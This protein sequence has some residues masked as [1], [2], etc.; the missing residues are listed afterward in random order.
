[1]PI[2][3]VAIILRCADWDAR[4]LPTDEEALERSRST[5]RSVRTGS[6]AATEPRP[7]RRPSA[8]TLGGLD[9]CP[10]SAPTRSSLATAHG[11]ARSAPAAREGSGRSPPV[12]HRRQTRL[13]AQARGT[14]AIQ[15]WLGPEFTPHLVVETVETSL[16]EPQAHAWALERRVPA[17]LR[18]SAPA[19]GHSKGG[20]AEESSER[21]RTSATGSSPERRSSSPAPRRQSESRGELHD[22]PRLGLAVLESR[23]RGAETTDLPSPSDTDRPTDGSVSVEQPFESHRGDRGCGDQRQQVQ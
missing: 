4:W 12:G 20:G 18:R 19:W 5:A 17:T 1:M 23:G 2:V 8:I 3:S 14:A 15:V 21:A 22:F 6:S 9:H 7:P 11:G 16:V 10:D 13:E